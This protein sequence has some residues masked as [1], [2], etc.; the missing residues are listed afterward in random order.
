MN[1]IPISMYEGLGVFLVILILYTLLKRALLTSLLAAILADVMAQSILNGNVVAITIIN[2]VVTYQAVQSL[3]IHYLLLGVAAIMTIL[4][5]YI[6][7][8]I[9]NARIENMSDGDEK[10]RWA[11][12]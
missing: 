3:P 9:I 5:F 1:E 4:T 6:L 10:P 12:E 11:D 8:M 7:L 2:N